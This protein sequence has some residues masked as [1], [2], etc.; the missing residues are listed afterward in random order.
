MYR[1]ISPENCAHLPGL[2]TFD[3]PNNPVSSLQA[4]IN[5]IL[6]RVHISQ[7]SFQMDE[8]RPHHL[9]KPRENHLSPTFHSQGP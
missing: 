9:E 2:T 7:P 8:Q 6:P 4:S 5:F 1:Y 3:L